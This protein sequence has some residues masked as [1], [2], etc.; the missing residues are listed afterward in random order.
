MEISSSPPKL[1]GMIRIDCG[2]RFLMPGLIDCHF[3]ACAPTYDMYG[4][5][6]M[7]PSLLAQF[8][9]RSLNQALMRGFTSVRDAGGA[10]IGFAMALEKGLIQGPRLFFSGRG[11]SQTGG[12]GDIR[13]SHRIE[14]CSCGYAGVMSLVAD[15]VDEVRKAVREELRRGATQIKLHVSGGVTSP[16]DP[17]WMPQFS[18]DEIRAA[19]E[20][21]AT[22]RTYV[23]AHCHTDDRARAC[24]ELGVRTIEH[25]TEI[26]PDTAELI[27]G[28]TVFV[29]PTLSVVS[30]LHVHSKELGLSQESISKIAGAHERTMI[31]MQNLVSAGVH[32]GLGTDL[33]GDYQHL[34]G[35]E[36]R[37]RASF[38]S[39]LDVLRSATSVNAEILQQP[40]ALGCIAPGAFADLLVLDGSPLEDISIFERAET[41]VALIMRNGEIVKNAL[42]VS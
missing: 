13:P 27:A 40:G 41:S 16:S 17:M 29:V 30:V 26:E 18:A 39:P 21:A 25:G 34:Q 8:G 5:D 11:I 20:E 15:G 2:G 7:P 42:A 32:L 12:H 10:D 4:L 37:L 6:R 23:M 33:L 3:H 35:G 28:S 14:P 36:F 24:V 22:R 1:D 19:V 9:A 31:T 38:S